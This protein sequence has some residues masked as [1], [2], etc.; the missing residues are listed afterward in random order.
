MLQYD[1][2]V[3]RSTEIACAKMAAMLVGRSRGGTVGS[4][5]ASSSVGRAIWAN[6][7][8]LMMFSKEVAGYAAQ[9]PNSSS[10]IR[11]DAPST[12]AV[13]GT[14]YAAEAC[15]KNGRKEDPVNTGCRVIRTPAA[16]L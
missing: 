15:D 8:N 7:M 5:V 10:S 6:R 14:Y 9:M 16:N 2:M 11:D 13:G 12:T 1:L 4:I 3:S